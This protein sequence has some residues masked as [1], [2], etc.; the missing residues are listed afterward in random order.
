[1]VFSIF[2]CSKSI[3]G[4]KKKPL[5]YVS[6]K[7]EKWIKPI[8]CPSSVNMHKTH[9][10]IFSNSKIFFFNTMNPYHMGKVFPPSVHLHMIK[11]V[12]LQ[13]YL[14][15]LVKLLPQFA[16]HVYLLVLL[17]IWIC[18][19]GKANRLAFQ[20]Q[21]PR[22]ASFC[23]FKICSK[24]GYRSKRGWCRKRLKMTGTCKVRNETERNETKSNE[25]KRNDVIFR[26]V[27]IGFVSFRS[28]SFC[29][30]SFRFVSFR[31]LQVPSFD[32]G[33]S[34]NEILELQC[35]VFN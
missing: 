35:N 14:Q 24:T 33:F 3:F 9:F 23:N 20:D 16:H 29:L 21:R 1:M 32:S 6:I 28:D 30:I 2:I 13:L 15:F 34:K 26:F 27:S 11:P 4:K 18:L 19:L 31:T 8:I 17:G 7:S 22:V 12:P 25:T 5:F 10:V